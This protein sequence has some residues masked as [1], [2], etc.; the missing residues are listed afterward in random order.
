MNPYVVVVRSGMRRR[1]LHPLLMPLY[2]CA[3][4]LGWWVCWVR[5][6]AAVCR[7]FCTKYS[8]PTARAL[9]VGCAVGGATFELS[10]YFD[11]VVGIDF[12]HAFVDTANELKVMD[13]FLL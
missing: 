6:T 3:Y 9:D 4:C 12:S 5:R 2:V 13:P 1:W 7:E 11:S 10:K 8:V